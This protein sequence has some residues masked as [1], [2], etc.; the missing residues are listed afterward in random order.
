M[1][2]PAPSVFGIVYGA[3]K[4]GKTATTLAAFHERAIYVAA[5]GALACS[6]NLWGFKVPPYEDLETLTD[7]LKFVRTLQPGQAVA[8]VVD[9]A[10]LLVDRT[11]AALAKIADPKN[12][13]DLW[14][15]LLG[16]ATELRDLL[17]HLRIHC[18]L[19]A[20]EVAPE[21]KQG[22]RLRG[23]P[24]FPGQTR[25]KLPAAA[26]LLLRTELRGGDAMFGGSSFGWPVVLRSGQSPDWL[27][28]DR[29]H[30]TPDP[31]PMNLG[32]LFRLAGFPLPRLRG[33]EWQEKV[34]E[35][36]AAVFQP[37]LGNAEVVKNIIV[38]ALGQMEAKG[39]PE[40]HA[41]WALR[42][43]YD[44]AVLLNAQRALRRGIWQL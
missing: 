44:R 21:V 33:L 12:Q 25:S 39:Y 22:V 1:T 19:T 15:R 38:Q 9:D 42:D 17:R 3:L 43:G 10:T 4:T 23:G 32:E 31:S 26:D 14:G 11:V 35:R 28:G 8:L 34:I 13:Y 41:L 37:Q 40:P 27:T 6:E 30:V 5:P 16:I 24:A 20:H 29:Y 18:L 36:L 2:A 7:V